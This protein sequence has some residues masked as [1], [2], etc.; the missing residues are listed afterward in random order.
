MTLIQNFNGLISIWE[1]RNR[2]DLPIREKLLKQ[3]TSEAFAEISFE[4]IKQIVGLADLAPVIDLNERVIKITD[5]LILEYY[6]FLQHFTKIAKSHINKKILKDYGSVLTIEA[7]KSPLFFEI[8]E[9][10]PEVNY[11]KLSI[12]FGQPAQ[13]IKARYLTG[14][15]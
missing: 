14:Y 11:E 7:N 2:D 1:Q 3:S 5:D 13:E 8:L 6:D 15:E 4:Q 9:R 10:S 12:L